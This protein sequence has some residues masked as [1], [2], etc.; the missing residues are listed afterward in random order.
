MLVRYLSR[1]KHCVSKPCECSKT[2]CIYVFE[3]D[4]YPQNPLLWLCFSFFSTCRCVIYWGN[5]H[6]NVLWLMPIHYKRQ[7][8]YHI[9][10]AMYLQVRLMLGK[11]NRVRGAGLEHPVKLL[12]RQAVFPRF[13][14]KWSLPCLLSAIIPSLS[15]QLAKILNSSLICLPPCY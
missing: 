11:K 7:L 13:S 8:G 1:K 3:N 6:Q 15:R 2:K 5:N 12:T 14:I 10:T 4:A 9:I